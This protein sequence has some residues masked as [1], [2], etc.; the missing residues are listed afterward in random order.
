MIAEIFYFFLKSITSLTQPRK[1]RSETLIFKKEFCEQYSSSQH[2]SDFEILN[3]Y[4]NQKI[5][6]N[7]PNRGK[8]L[9]IACGPGYLLIELAK[10]RPGVF[11][12]G[13]DVSPE[14]L[15]IARK[16]IDKEKVSNIQLVGLSQFKIFL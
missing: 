7:L 13:I 2:T 3:T 12:S 10:Q 5:L 16:N 8:F 15:I 11:W 14:M 9:D 6:V 1:P 4:I